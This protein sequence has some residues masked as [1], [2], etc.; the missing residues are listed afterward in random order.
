MDEVGE[1]IQIQ[2]TDK[3]I[4][5][6]KTVICTSYDRKG[7]FHGALVRVQETI[8]RTRTIGVK[9]K[10]KDKVIILLVSLPLSYEHLRITLTYGEDKLGID[11]VIA[12]L[13]SHESMH[14]KESGNYSRESYGCF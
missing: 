8:D 9:I 11:E 5:F 2:I 13:L 6:K 14:K 7:K 12:T 10:E 3:A 1:Q 4:V